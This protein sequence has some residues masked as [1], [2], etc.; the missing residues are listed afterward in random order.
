MISDERLD[1]DFS[2]IVLSWCDM[3]RLS[4]SSTEGVPVEKCETLLVLNLV[5]EERIHVPG[6]MGTPTGVARI[7]ERGKRYLTYAKRDRI[8]RVITR[9]VAIWG[10]ITGT[11]AL[12]WQI[13]ERFIHP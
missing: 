6:Y 9:T 11:G 5:A 13:F 2:E 7:T 4:K 8:D 12:V 1:I 10:A 3:R